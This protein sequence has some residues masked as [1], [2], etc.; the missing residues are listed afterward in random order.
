[1]QTEFG[2]S[3]KSNTTAIVHNTG[4]LANCHGAPTSI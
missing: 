2:Q 3:V 4:L 1:M